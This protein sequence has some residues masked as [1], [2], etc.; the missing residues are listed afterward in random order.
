METLPFFKK[1]HTRPLFLYFRLFNTVDNKQM[2]DKSLPMTGFEPWISGVK[3]DRST[4]EPTPLP[5]LFRENLGLLVGL[6][7]FNREWG[8]RVGK[9]QCDQIGRFFKVLGNKSA[10]KS[11]PKKMGDIWANLKRFELCKNWCGYHLGTFWKQLGNFLT[12]ISGHTGK[13]ESKSII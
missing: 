2:L 10:I 1:N 11:S 12:P 4:T 9:Y 5:N 3:G 6:I 13:N 8:E 7:H